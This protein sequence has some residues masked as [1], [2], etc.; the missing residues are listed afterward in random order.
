VAA[1]RA[2]GPAV[3]CNYAQAVYEQHLTDLE[4][5]R[6]N[7]LVRDGE[8]APAHRPDIQARL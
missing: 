4:R 8:A 3:V 2:D 7:D 6:H 1:A 5:D